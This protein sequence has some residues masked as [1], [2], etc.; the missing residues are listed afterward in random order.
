[1]GKEVK[2]IDCPGGSKTSGSKSALDE[3]LD[4]LPTKEEIINLSKNNMTLYAAIRYGEHHNLEWEKTMMFAVV[5]LV[6]GNQE[7]QDTMQSW[8]ERY[9]NP[10]NIAG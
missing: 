10:S 9:G 2:I 1:M 8:L 6:N 5:H 4:L 7:L 3:L